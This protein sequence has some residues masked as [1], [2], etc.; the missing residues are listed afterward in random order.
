M[1]N[2]GGISCTEFLG[3]WSNVLTSTHTDFSNTS[4]RPHVDCQVMSPLYTCSPMPSNSP[5]STWF[6][7]ASDH[8]QCHD[9]AG[10]VAPRTFLST[11]SRLGTEPLPEAPKCAR[12]CIGTRSTAP[13]QFGDDP[14]RFDFLQ[15]ICGSGLGL[16]AARP[17]IYSPYV[18]HGCLHRPRREI[19]LSFSLSVQ[20]VQTAALGGR[21]P[22]PAAD[23]SELKTRSCSLAIVRRGSGVIRQW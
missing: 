21:R 12:R 22:A 9:T 6:I 10:P 11:L 3:R 17:Q 14:D 18:R 23:V 4:A 8:L 15:M 16:F 13:D 5:T 1:T 19:S 2:H 20:R 7:H